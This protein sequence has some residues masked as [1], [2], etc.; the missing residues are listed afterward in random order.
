M[1]KK[2]IGASLLLCKFSQEHSWILYVRGVRAISARGANSEND[3]IF[4][5]CGGVTL[6]SLKKPSL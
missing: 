4:L 3:M 2:N 5:G 6:P 1:K